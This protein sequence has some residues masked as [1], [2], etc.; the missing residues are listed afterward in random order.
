VKSTRRNIPK[1]VAKRIFRGGLLV[2][3]PD[4]T[5]TPSVAS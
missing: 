3:H 2:C 1:N 4:L 5:T